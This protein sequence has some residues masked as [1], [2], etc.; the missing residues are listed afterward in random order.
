MVS[1]VEVLD[2]R[3]GSW[4][5]VEPMKASRGYFSSFVLGGR[6]YVIGGEHNNKVLDMVRDTIYFW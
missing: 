4:M 3:I 1:S 6:I 2:P 5:M